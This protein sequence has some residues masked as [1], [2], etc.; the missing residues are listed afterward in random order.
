M[1][2]KGDNLPLFY[3][4]AETERVC[5]YARNQ[6]KLGRLTHNQINEIYH[7]CNVNTVGRRTRDR[8]SHGATSSQKWRYFVQAPN[9][10]I[11]PSTTTTRLPPC[12]G[13]SSSPMDQQQWQTDVICDESPLTVTKRESRQRVCRRQNERLAPNCIKHK[14]NSKG[15]ER[16]FFTIQRKT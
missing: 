13:D 2:Q 7:K 1:S 5:N 3:Q 14:G 10:R 4:C 15:R 11:W 6:R 9:Q 8:S 12:L 16:P